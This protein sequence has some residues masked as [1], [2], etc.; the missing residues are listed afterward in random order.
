MY[1]ALR[2]EGFNKQVSTVTKVRNR[3]KFNM[4]LV[5]QFTAN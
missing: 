5:S 4:S 3:A 2:S 1:D